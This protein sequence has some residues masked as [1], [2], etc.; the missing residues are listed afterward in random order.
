MIELAHLAPGFWRW[1]I[2]LALVRRITGRPAPEVP[3]PEEMG[4]PD[5][6]SVDQKK[7]IIDDQSSFVDDLPLLE[8]TQKFDFPEGTAEHGQSQPFPLL[9]SQNI[10]AHC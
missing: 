9:A 7:E 1:L 8:K 5:A 3:G 4:T 10:I 6:E 2:N